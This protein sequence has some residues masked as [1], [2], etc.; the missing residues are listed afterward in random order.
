MRIC[1][2]SSVFL[3]LFTSLLVHSR[4][5]L[6]V[7]IFL[8]D[9]CRISQEMTPHLNQIYELYGKQ[10]GF[11]G[12]F[13][14]KATSENGMQRFIDKY[15]IK[16]PVKLDHDKVWAKKWKA[17]VLP[18]VVLVNESTQT[19]IYRGLIN[20]LYLRPGKRRHNIKN[21]YLRVAIEEFLVGNKPSVTVT[22]P[23]GCFINF[24]DN[25]TN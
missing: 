4:D 14:N 11:T 17:T 23:V 10:V 7:Y 12:I 1:R 6:T 3:C 5:S 16:F 8:L 18:E 20:D 9:E 19:V 22:T 21:H 25:E 15:R 24:Q 13:P 2:F